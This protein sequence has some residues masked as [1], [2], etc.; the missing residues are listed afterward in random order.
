MLRNRFVSVLAIAA[1]AGVLVTGGCVSAATKPPAAAATAS[2]RA[3]AATGGAANIVI[4]GVNTDGAYWHAIVS[5]V[6]ALVRMRPT[7][8]RRWWHARSDR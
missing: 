7:Y 5:E 1:F 3:A 8:T 6:T 2:V 4:Y